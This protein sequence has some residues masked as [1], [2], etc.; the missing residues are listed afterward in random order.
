[1]ITALCGTL[2]TLTHSFQQID[3]ARNS[4]LAAQ[5]MQSEI[6]SVRLKNFTDLSKI[7]TAAQNWYKADLTK[8]TSDTKIQERFAETK[9][10]VGADATRT[11]IVWI[12]V[13]VIWTNYSGTESTRTFK[14]KYSKNGLHDYYYTIAR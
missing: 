14:T 8:I 13:D 3:T 7:A 9:V 5:I 4:T 12:T 2:Y 11:D 1:M 6:E 10:T